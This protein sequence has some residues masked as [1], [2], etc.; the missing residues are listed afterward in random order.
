MHLRANA[1]HVIPVVRHGQTDTAFKKSS[2]MMLFVTVFYEK[3]RAKKIFP[4]TSYCLAL[5][6]KAIA[7]VTK[8]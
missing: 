5:K 7:P 1:L 8:I 4:S 6:L 3:T 2:F